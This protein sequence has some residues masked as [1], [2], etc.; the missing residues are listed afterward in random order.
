MTGVSHEHLIG[1]L[2]T[3]YPRGQALRI[4][5]AEFTRNGAVQ[6]EAAAE[7]NYMKK[8]EQTILTTHSKRIDSGG[9]P[10]APANL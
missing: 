2:L 4:D 5:L 8:Q 1:R 9:E 10:G 6:L 3:A 7:K